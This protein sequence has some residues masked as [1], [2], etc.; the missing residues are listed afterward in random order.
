MIL[1]KLE[2]DEIFFIKLIKIAKNKV[3]DF[4][5]VVSPVVD[6]KPKKKE[7]KQGVFEF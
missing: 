7:E 2:M 4:V 6:L 5:S 3:L 1:K